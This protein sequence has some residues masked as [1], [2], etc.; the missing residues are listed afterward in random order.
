MKHA[1]VALGSSLGASRRC[2]ALAT[3]ML[4]ATPDITLLSTSRIFLTP[5]DGGVARRPFLNAAVHLQTT[6]PP[7]ALLARCRFIEQRLGLQAQ[8]SSPGLAFAGQVQGSKPSAPCPPR[9]FLP[10]IPGWLVLISGIID[11]KP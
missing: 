2:L 4:G 10:T 11:N 7:L 8:P 1:A 6:L 5:P 9:N 3:A